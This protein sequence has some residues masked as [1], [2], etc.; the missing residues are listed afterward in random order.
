MRTKCAKIFYVSI[1]KLSKNGVIWLLK[2]F[3]WGVGFAQN[4]GSFD[5]Y[6]KHIIR[7]IYFSFISAQLWATFKGATRPADR[8]L[9]RPGVYG[10]KSIIEIMEQCQDPANQDIN[11]CLTWQSN[12]Y[13]ILN[14]ASKLPQQLLLACI[15][16]QMGRFMRLCTCT[17]TKFWQHQPSGK[18]V[19]KPFFVSC[20]IVA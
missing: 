8:H 11:I 15:L 7:P 6:M 4:K 12:K 14:S 10:L 13:I 16:A 9:R 3:K 2:R 20:S 1:F 5:R 18:Q 17:T 19:D